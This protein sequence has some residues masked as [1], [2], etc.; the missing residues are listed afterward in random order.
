MLGATFAVAAAIAI[1]TPWLFHEAGEATRGTARANA[2]IEA[3]RTGLA[4]GAGAG[5]AAGL[6]LAFRRQHHHE[7]I[8]ALADLD[9]TEKRITDLYTK[10]ADQLGSGQAAV[11]LAGLYAL[12]RVAQNNLSMRQTIV[13]V[14]CAYLRMPYTPPEPADTSSPR[15]DA[16]RNHHRD[17][18]ATK[19]H[20]PLPPVDA[21]PAADPH[22]E[23]QVRLTAQRILI[24][25]LRPDAEDV[26]AAQRTFWAR[27]NID[28]I[29]ATLIDFDFEGCVVVNAG[30]AGAKFFGPA[31]FPDAKFAFDAWFPGA[32]FADRAC[33]VDAKFSGPAV[34]EGAVFSGPAEFEGAEF[35]SFSAGFE[36]ATFSGDAVFEGTKFTDGA[37]FHGAIFSGDVRFEGASVAL[38]QIAASSWP[39]RWAP[40]RNGVLYESTTSKP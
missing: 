31:R 7:H 36:D 1:T 18:H 24:K 28:L 38:S 19:A 20:R 9:A 23:K 34:F 21:A 3:V 35:L 33:F 16:I 27:T 5:A 29:G 4:A 13:D 8:S 11:R 6:L 37:E 40:D 26:P 17:Y 30:F 10:A 12:E 2:R 25:H 14:I 32:E 15:A 39:T 22:G